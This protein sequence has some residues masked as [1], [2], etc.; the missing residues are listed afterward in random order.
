MNEDEIYLV[1]SCEILSP[2]AS[3]PC[4]RG[5]CRNVNSTA[6][7]CLCQAG[8]TGKETDFDEI[9]LIIYL[10]NSC[11]LPFDVCTSNPCK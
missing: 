7:Q 6:F 2:C 4:I 8:F 9:R 11:E 10:G 3:S 1:I 5:T